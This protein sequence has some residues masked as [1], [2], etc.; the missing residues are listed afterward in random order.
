VV[1]PFVGVSDINDLE[2][3]VGQYVLYRKILD[4]Q[5]EMRI[6]YIAIT[7]ITFN[8]VFSS[9]LGQLLLVDQTICLM[10]FDDESEVVTQW[11]PGPNING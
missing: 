10:V 3:A 11:I 6:L 4:K 2:Q 5:E 8:T 1:K 9:E 7:Q